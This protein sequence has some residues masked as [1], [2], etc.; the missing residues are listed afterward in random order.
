MTQ[1]FPISVLNGA[2]APA[3]NN[4]ISAL[5]D[6]NIAVNTVDNNGV[7]WGVPPPRMWGPGTVPAEKWLAEATGGKAFFYRNDLD[8]ALAEGIAD[9][10]S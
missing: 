7:D 3:W 1:G 9:S 5:N 4:T 10:R 8:G 6:A 2:A